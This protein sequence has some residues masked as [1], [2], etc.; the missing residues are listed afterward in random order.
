MQALIAMATFT[1]MYMITILVTV[2]MISGAP[3]TDT[4]MDVVENQ[5]NDNNG[6]KINHSSLLVDGL[7]EGDLELSE[8]YIRK[9]YDFGA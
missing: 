4:K 9:F 1:L 8:D 5:I 7:F 6:K 2:Q 3:I